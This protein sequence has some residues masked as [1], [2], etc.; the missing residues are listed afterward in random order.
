MASLSQ[1]VSSKPKTGEKRSVC[2]EKGKVALE[3][4]SYAV[5][6]KLNKTDRTAPV[7]VGHIPR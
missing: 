3:I 2:K 5:A 4:D 6:W 7:V 1:I